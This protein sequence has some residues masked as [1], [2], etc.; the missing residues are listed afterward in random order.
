MGKKSQRKGAN[1]ERELTSILQGYGYATKRGGSETFGT[2]PD[3]VGLPGIHIECKRVERLDLLAAMQ[4]AQ[5]DA[6]RFGDGKPA[7]FHRKNR[8][9]WLV[10]MT[11]EDW[12]TLYGKAVTCEC[13]AIGQP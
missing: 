1:G 9:E 6:A 8:S 11:L 12:I 2:I 5:R 7:V 4:Q 13:G 10:T 3:I